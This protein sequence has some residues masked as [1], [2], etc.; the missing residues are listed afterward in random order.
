MGCS[1]DLKRLPSSSSVPGNVNIF[2]NLGA[3]FYLMGDQRYNIRAILDT[4]YLP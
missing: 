2:L 3:K 4:K 1:Y